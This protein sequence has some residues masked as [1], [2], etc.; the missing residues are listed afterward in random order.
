V[1]QAQATAVSSSP[2]SDVE[3]AAFDRFVVIWL[4]NTDFS[5]AAGDPN[6]KNLAAQGI[7]LNSL[8]GVTH[9]S[10]PN[11]M[12]SHGGDYFGLD[13]DGLCYIDG[14]VSSIYDLLDTKGISYGEYQEDMP[15]AG[16]EGFGYTSVI[17]NKT[18]NDYV[19]KHNPAVL[20]NSIT[21]NAQRLSTIKNF[22]SFYQDLE[23]NTLPQWMFIT[24]NMTNDGHDTSVTTAGSWS[25]SFLQPLLSNP[26][27][28]GPKTL[29]L[30]TFDEN[31]TYTIANNIFGMLLGN[32]VPE[33]LIGTIDN[34][35]YNHYSQISTV[36]ANWGLPTL[37]RWDVGANVYDFVGQQ[38][39]DAIKPW[40]TVNGTFPAFSSIAFNQSYPGVFNS[41]VNQTFYPTPNTAAIVNGRAV[42]PTIQQQFAGKPSSYY[43]GNV[44]PEIYDGRFPPAAW[45]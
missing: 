20:Y 26:N 13:G 25:A 1:K 16:F 15:Y 17:N 4:E 42:L 35:F 21:D 33:S 12:A 32:A 45:F 44:G 37:G 22:T 43:P 19:R 14:S 11:Y 6:L 36:S 7:S 38:T 9:P 27:F 39:G 41:K 28:N 8:F 30:L 24:P 18:A 10:E 31:H 34:Q 29:I 3:G 40:T 2:T 23:A 5:A